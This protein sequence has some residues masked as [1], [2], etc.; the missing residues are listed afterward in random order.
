MS[1][2]LDMK[3]FAYQFPQSPARA[4]VT[5]EKNPNGEDM[6][7]TLAVQDAALRK[8]LG[9][10]GDK[11]NGLEQPVALVSNGRE[12]QRFPMRYVASVGG[13]GPQPNV[14]LYELVLGSGQYDTIAAIQQGVALMLQTNVG[15]VWL[16]KEDDNLK[17]DPAK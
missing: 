17:Y 16:Q 2:V 13:S 6:R 7:V 1:T 9:A 12:F 3:S 4:N 15:D 14:D 8:A 10:D 11:F 5:I